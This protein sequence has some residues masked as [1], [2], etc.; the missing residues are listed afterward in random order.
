MSELYIKKVKIKDLEQQQGHHATYEKAINNESSTDTNI[1]KKIIKNIPFLFG[2]K[3]NE[4]DWKK[5]QKSIEDN[6]YNPAKYGYIEVREKPNAKGKLEIYNGNH[7]VFILEKMFGDDYEVEVVVNKNVFTLIFHALLLGLKNRKNK[8]RKSKILNKVSL[9]EK[10]VR[11]VYYSQ[12]IVLCTYFFIFN[13]IP[14]ALVAILIYLIYV[15][16]KPPTELKKISFTKNK[17][18]DVLIKN[19]YYNNQ[20]ILTITLILIYMLHL[21]VTDFVG[22][23]L[24]IGYCLIAQGIIKNKSRV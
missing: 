6:G 22:F 9:N 21:I 3:V 1:F 12:L 5:L 11:I 14:S 18:T 10:I 16:L 24:V 17:F 2:L 4:Y 20:L 23:I 7:R 15:H 13:F 8:I 19:L